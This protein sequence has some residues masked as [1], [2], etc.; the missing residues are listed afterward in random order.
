MDEDLD[1][2]LSPSAA[3]KINN[4]RLPATCDPPSDQNPPKQAV[5]IVC[6]S[7]VPRGDM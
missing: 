2:S 1:E 7:E 3:S 6:A 5:W 4:L